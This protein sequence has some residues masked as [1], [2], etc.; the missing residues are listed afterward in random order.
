[1]RLGPG[2][3]FVSEFVTSARRW[4]VYAIRV[5]FVTG[6]LA[7]MFVVRLSQA[8]SNG[9]ATIQAQ[10]QVGESY[11]FA[12]IG[13]QLALV[14][15]VAPAFT[16]GAICLDRARG[17]LAHVLVTDLTDAEIVL[18]KLGTRLMPV[19][20]LVACTFPLTILGSL[21]GGIDPVALGL[22]FLVALAVAILSCALAL[23]ISVWAT[24]THEVLMAVYAFW[25]VVLLLQPVWELLAMS[26][27]GFL[28]PPRWALTLNPYWLSFS[29]YIAP[30]Q[31][32]WVDFAVFLGGSLTLSAAL[33]AVS[34]VR[35][36]PVT[37]N[38]AGRTSGS[39]KSR[40]RL[41]LSLVARVWRFLPG[42]SLDG[43]PV[44]WRE[45][46]RG[47]SS[48][49]TRLI[50]WA[51]FG[52]LSY[53]GASSVYAIYRN[54]LHLGP[55][56]GAFVIMLGIGLGLL[57]LSV[58]ASSSLSEERTCGSLDVLLATRLPTRTILW[59]KWWG[60]YRVVP[61]LALW[62]TVIMA[63][64]AFSTPPGVYQQP[65]SDGARVFSVVLMAMIVL[66]HGAALTSLGLALATWVPR[67]GRA[68]GFCVA[69]YL[70][71]SVGWLILIAALSPRRGPNGS[72][73]SLACLSPIF[74]SMDLWEHMVFPHGEVARVFAVTILW[75]G[76]VAGAAVLLYALTL[77]TF[78]RC[79]GRTSDWNDELRFG[80]EP[81]PLRQSLAS[82]HIAS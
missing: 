58:T 47:R 32:H 11:F 40:S 27:A 70:M 14:M 82:G 55:G 79:L 64:F 30:N 56:F 10:A 59:G 75:L 54:G 66:V 35:L 13:T 53:G 19:V 62:P 51:Y 3:V 81:R 29:P 45:W 63:V 4:Q 76:V 31:V 6:L 72:V 12:L 37:A 39:R 78:D 26:G 7:A 50:W 41:S 80:P 17:V 33:T 22:A 24:K 52:T 15:L 2:P 65:L 28:G 23:T 5:L 61:L 20:G 1:M 36:R 49:L 67:Q 74:G 48:R 9:G 25:T 57:L 77:A 18:G 44:L 46:H 43:N 68:V 34:I 71:V 69:A 38:L 42:P 60:A 21:L 16:A 73:E 8:E